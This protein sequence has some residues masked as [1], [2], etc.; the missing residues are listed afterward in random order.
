MKQTAIDG[1]A[2]FFIVSHVPTSLE[3]YCKMLGFEIV[4]RQPDFEPFFAILRRGAA[5]IRTHLQPS[6]RRV[7]CRFLAPLKIPMGAKT[8]MP[9][10]VTTF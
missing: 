4:Y 6:L 8:Q 5:K 1:M 3:S 2:P 10:N 7:M 9:P